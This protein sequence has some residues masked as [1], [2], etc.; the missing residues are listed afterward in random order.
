MSNQ[1]KFIIINEGSNGEYSLAIRGRKLVA[2]LYNPRDP[3]QRWIR[4]IDNGTK[5]QQ[6]EPA[7]VLV[8]EATNEAIKNEGPNR[9]MS[10]V[11]YDKVAGSPDNLLLWT[12]SK[13]TVQGFKYLCQ[14][15]NVLYHIMP[16]FR[17]IRDGRMMV[18]YSGI[19]TMDRWKF[20]SYNKD[21]LVPTQQT[22]TISC[23][24]KEGY[25]LTIRDETVMLAPADPKDKYQVWI[26]EISYAKPVKDQDAKQ[27]FAL[28][29]KATGKAIKPGFGTNFLVHLAKFNQDYLDSSLLWTESEKELGFREIRMQSN[30][31][32]VFHANYVGDAADSN[33]ALLELRSMNDSKD[34]RWKLQEIVLWDA[35]APAS[36][37]P[38]NQWDPSKADIS[39]D[40]SK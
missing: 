35:S 38:S 2:A 9:P 13:E 25:N 34:Q 11:P 32:A 22:I 15:N 24:S 39:F 17:A 6:G 37:K 19:H 31:S 40:G 18:L 21:L 14:A 5:S 29:N 23:Q 8:N 3:Y 1:E 7:F 20:V 10:L 30:T 26:K 33:E 16:N 27:A 28:V 36:E 12:E 4:K